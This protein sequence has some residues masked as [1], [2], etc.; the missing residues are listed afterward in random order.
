VALR[1]RRAT[2]EQLRRALTR[3]KRRGPDA[4]PAGLRM[5]VE[6]LSDVVDLGIRAVDK[7]LGGVLR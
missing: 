3:I 7:A 6:T 5:D 1:L 2:V 4:I